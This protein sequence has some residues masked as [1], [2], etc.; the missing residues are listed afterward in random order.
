MNIFR[1]RWHIST[2]VI[3][4]PGKVIGLSFKRKTYL[5]DKSKPQLAAN[6]IQ[7]ISGRF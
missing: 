1:V 5:G 6:E 4:I 7:W 2:G 3:P